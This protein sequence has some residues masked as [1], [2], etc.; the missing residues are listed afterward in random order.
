MSAPQTGEITWYAEDRSALRPPLVLLGAI[1]PLIVVLA[2]A[3]GV[4]AHTESVLLIIVI[5]LLLWVFTDARH[6]MLVWP[7]GLRVDA[8]GIR[9]G[10]VRR[11]ERKPG[12]KARKKP[13]PPSFQGY[14][15]F[16]CPWQGVRSLEVVTDR[17][18]LRELKRE[19]TRAP[20]SEVHARGG[21]ALGY[22]LGMLATPFMRAALVIEVDPAYA[23]YPTF[24]VQQALSV[25]TS[26]QGTRSSTWLVPTRHADQVRGLV[27]QVTASP[28]WTTRYQGERW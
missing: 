7:V 16:T 28:K 24:R 14:H 2:A 8:D 19:S 27:A 11:A 25:A 22:Y 21:I 15:V 17:T 13:P 5:A 3:F 1:L 9:I 10:G 18:R 26:Q 20:K 6:L 23:R 4:I 12:R